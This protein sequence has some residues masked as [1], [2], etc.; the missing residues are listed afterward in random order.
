MTLEQ[1]DLIDE[2]FPP[3]GG[4][5]QAAPLRPAPLPPAPLPPAEP[6]KPKPAVVTKNAQLAD[7]RNKIGNAQNIL[8]G[9]TA[10][11]ADDFDSTNNQSS[12]RPLLMADTAPVAFKNM[13]EVLAPAND[14]GEERKREEPLRGGVHSNGSAAMVGQRLNM[15]GSTAA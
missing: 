14:L 7:L 1:A 15:Q 2:H 11:A 9:K 13:P 3:G 6:P 5:G 10:G 12:V 4:G 8:D